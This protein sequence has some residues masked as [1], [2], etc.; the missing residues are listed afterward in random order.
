MTRR[1]AIIYLAAFLL[2]WA[3]WRTV[4]AQQANTSS[5][6]TMPAP[7]GR[8]LGTALKTGE[9][10]PGVVTPAA[11]ATG[12]IKTEP[13]VRLEWSGPTSVRV[14]QP[15]D[16]VLTVRN[17]S[18]S[19]VSDVRLR[20]SVDAKCVV[21]AE[22]RPQVEDGSLIWD[23][24]GFA[25]KHERQVQVRLQHGEKGNIGATARV[26]FSSSA[27]IAIRASEP[28][29]LVRVGGASKCQLGDGT[30]LVVTVN[31]PG[32]GVAERV[33]VNVEIPE[34]LEHVKGRLV[35]YDVG[36]L[37]PGETRTLQV[38]C[39]ARAG[40]EHVCKATAEADGGLKSTDQAVVAVIAPR[41]AVEI[42]GPALRYL[43]RKASYAIRVTNPG[44]A[45][46]NNVL[47]QDILPGG[48]RFV[49]ADAGGRYDPA[50]RI[51]SWYV[52][53]IA[54]GESRDVTVELQATNMGEFTHEVTAQASRGL[55][56][57]QNLP[58]R[59][60]GISAILLE[61]VDLEDPIEVGA[62]TTY[63]VRIANTGSKADHDLRLVCQ[64]PERMQFRGATGP[65]GFSQNG[66]EIVFHPLPSLGARSDA[67]YRVTVRATA[68]GVSTFKARI[69]SSILVDPVLKE[70]ATRVYSD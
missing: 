31:N 5:N 35:S 55:K 16:Y 8:E 19:N 46:A 17:V 65:T 3:G 27:A 38:L 30:G 23:L 4:G 26:T 62:D 7:P 40:G 12:P 66:Q 18:E 69:T 37:Q 28:S 51:V 15:N 59:V 39:V 47:L 70:E 67:V 60:E 52:G 9:F 44:D 24:G 22:P 49:S 63:V 2:S 43:D 13:A 29:L 45:P 33:K 34:G 68:A 1:Y 21:G 58:V 56:S 14:G 25:P 20:V 64:I 36:A 57:S 53:E 48:F 50:T 10:I 54:P 6:P 61:V 42:K 32:D 41:L 11:N